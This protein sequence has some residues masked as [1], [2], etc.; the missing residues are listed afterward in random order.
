MIEFR[1]LVVSYPGARSNAVDGV[2]F[3]GARGKLT[4][5]AGPNLS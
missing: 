1:D 5:L 4:A 2:T 3:I